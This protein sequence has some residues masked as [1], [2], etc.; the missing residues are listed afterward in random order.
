MQTEQ[1]PVVT[2][3]TRNDQSADFIK[4][5]DSNGDAKIDTAII[6]QVSIGEVGYVSSEKVI[7]ETTTYETADNNIAEDV[8]EDDYAVI[9]WNRFDECNDVVKAQKITSA[10]LNGTKTLPNKY[11]LGD[12]WYVEMA[13]VPAADMHGVKAGDVIDAWVYNGV[14]AYAK[15]SSGE[16]ATLA[17]VCVVLAKGQNIEGDKVKVLKLDTSTTEIVTMDTNPGAGYVANPKTAL[18]MGSVYEYSVKDG[19]Y[20]FK[21]LSETPDYFGDY[22]SLNT[23]DVAV[24][25]NKSN[26]EVF[27]SGT[28]EAVN[29]TNATIGGEIVSDSA[30][31]VLITNYKGGSGGTN[32]VD[33]KVVTGKQFKTLNV[34]V[35]TVGTDNFEVYTNGGIAAFTSKVDGVTRVTYAVVAVEGLKPAFELADNYG[36]ITATDYT[37]PDGYIVYTVWTGSESV[38]VQEKNSVPR[39]KG[40]IIGYSSIQ[41]KGDNDAFAT[42]KDVSSPNF[43]M[44]AATVNDAKDKISLDGSSQLNITSSTKILYIDSA[45]Y[46]GMESGTLRDASTEGGKKLMNV[47]IIKDGT[48]DL[49][50]LV[51]DVT[52]K[53]TNMTSNLPSDA[54]VTDINNALLVGDANLSNSAGISID[55][56]VNIP[57][58]STLTLDAGSSTVTLTSGKTMDVK[59]NLVVDSKIVTGTGASINVS[60]T[61]TVTLNGE[62][63]NFPKITGTGN[64]VINANITKTDGPGEDTAMCF[65]DL[66]KPKVNAVAGTPV[67]V[68]DEGVKLSG[69]GCVNGFDPGRSM[70]TLASRTNSKTVTPYMLTLNGAAAGSLT[71]KIT[72]KDGTPPEVSGI[73][74]EGGS[75]NIVDADLSSGALQMCVTVGDNV[76]QIVYTIDP[77]DDSANLVWTFNFS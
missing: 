72:T 31:I 47:A 24:N 61:G 62:T 77:S 56:D 63:E 37:A 39:A 16:N 66:F 68:T 29:K 45:N 21:P 69:P 65:G 10:A 19:E 28:G 26:D 17:D 4:F 2:G 14:I 49:A 52:N 54:A 35:G 64:V 51:Y 74:A 15:R 48:K 58:G 12:T 71:G 76:K 42:I 50:L 34:G 33:Y 53:L 23:G 55:D 67:N 11:M 25:W 27:A 73:F 8:A 18:E 20:R 30:K 22:T 57:A 38:T 6:N 43:V 36:Y 46:K 9:T 59:G 13:G 60:E 40:E 1:P 75:Q 7:V 5:V 70:N 41:A 44:G 3:L 32:D